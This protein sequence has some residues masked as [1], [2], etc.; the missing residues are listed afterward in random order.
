[1]TVEVGVAV[2]VGGEPTRIL[3]EVPV[4]ELSRVSVAV[5]VQVPWVF[6]VVVK[7]LTPASEIRKV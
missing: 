5:R 3:P 6:I 7:L 4:I 2:G 1:M